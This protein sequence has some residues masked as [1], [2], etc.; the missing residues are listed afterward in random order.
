MCVCCV[1]YAGK[2]QT[3]LTDRSACEGEG[4][5]CDLSVSLGSQV[6]ACHRPAAAVLLYAVSLQVSRIEVTRRVEMSDITCQVRRCS[7]TGVSGAGVCC[8]SVG[9]VCA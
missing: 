3:D 9:E 6:G 5:R 2:R 4:R 7:C 8:L 1:S